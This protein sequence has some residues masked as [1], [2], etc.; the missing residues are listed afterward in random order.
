MTLPRNTDFA[1]EDPDQLRVDLQ[2]EHRDIVREFDR[3][4][5]PHPRWTV[6]LVGDSQTARAAPDM[7]YAG[8]NFTLI[9]PGNPTPGASLRV[10][11]SGLGP[12]GI[13]VTAD[14]GSAIQGVVGIDNIGAVVSGWFEYVFVKSSVDPRVAGWWRNR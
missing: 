5:D 6:E 12:T 13:N 7:V 11:S 10:L 8:T 9:L 14:D 2:S 4:G 3:V 1:T